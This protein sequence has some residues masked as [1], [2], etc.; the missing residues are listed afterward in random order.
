MDKN[1]VLLEGLV[2]DDFKYGK[3]QEGK[4]FATFSLSI[5]S[6]FKEMA[7]ST[8]RTHSQTYIRIFVYDKK[9]VEYLHKVN[10]HRGQRVSIFGR[11]VSFKSEHKGITFMVNNVVCRDIN[12]IKNKRDETEG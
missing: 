12:I 3:T 4:E 11:L 7:D 10:A 6:F 9:Q 5:N 8:E 1:V 2:G